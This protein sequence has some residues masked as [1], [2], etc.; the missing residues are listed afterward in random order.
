MCSPS[1]AELPERWPADGSIES[2][3]A[4][5]DWLPASVA[6]PVRS[7]NSPVG[8]VGTVE[9]ADVASVL[10][11]HPPRHA[12]KPCG[13]RRFERCK[14]ARMHDI[15][16]ERAEQVEES[17]IKPEAMARLFCQ[18]KILNIVAQNAPSKIRDF[19]QRDD[20]MA[21][22]FCRKSIDQIDNTVFETANIEAKHDVRN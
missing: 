4:L 6:H 18:R 5:L 13:Q 7:T 16:L 2:L 17:R 8:A 3:P 9:V 19:G 10:A 21:I 11:M 12:G 15:R 14:I 22:R 20:C 1:C